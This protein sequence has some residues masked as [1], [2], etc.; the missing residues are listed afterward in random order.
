MATIGSNHADP[1]PR[2]I[3]PFRL[4]ALLAASLLFHVLAFQWADGRIGAP[5]WPKD[6]PQVVTTQL[7]NIPPSAK[8]VPAPPVPKAAPPAPRP[9]PNPAPR[10]T[11]RTTHPPPPPPAL[12]T[13]G[14]TPSLP[15]A[16]VEVPGTSVEPA[17]A[18]ATAGEAPGQADSADAASAA[19][20]ASGEPPY[21]VSPPPSAELKYGVHSLRKG[22]AAHGYG[23][24]VWHADGSSYRITGEAGVLFFSLLEFRSEG[25]LD[26]SGVAP[27]IYSEKRFRKPETNTHFHRERDTISFS[28]S[29]RS[30]PRSGG[31]QDRASVVWQLAGIGRA[32]P[33]K[34]APDAEL[35]IFVAGVRDAE[36]WRVRVT[37][38][39]ELNFG[40][41]KIA[42]WHL[43]RV[44]RRGS[45]DQQLDIW[46][47][48]QY[49][50]FPVKLRF[51]EPNGD[52]FE[53]SLSNFELASKQ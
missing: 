44:P 30:Y 27:V 42:T 26:D 23:K 37:G 45:Y 34:F 20:D 40:L 11:A 1:P 4:A 2:R 7:L 52:Y 22:Q 48:P 39:E 5:S 21:K 18:L 38:M 36:N 35:E 43:V 33:A 53:M 31:E 29:T 49:E 50:W 46:L 28:A 14:G 10:S 12:P 32:D 41:D 24:I 9:K 15:P 19:A 17:V 16:G 8:T 13:V 25:M 51:T 3:R 6:S 47:A